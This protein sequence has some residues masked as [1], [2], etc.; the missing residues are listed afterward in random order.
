MKKENLLSIGAL[1]KQT[2]VHIKSLRYYDSLGI[3]RPAYVDPSSGYRYY[4]L[5]QIPVVDAIQLCVDLDI[6][7]KHFTDYYLDS[8][9][10]IHYSKL[11][12]RGTIL[13]KEKIQA[14]QERLD[15]LEEMRSEIKRGELIQKS[16]GMVQCSFP[17]MNLLLAPY[18]END[19]EMKVIALFHKLV[20]TAE[21]SGLTIN[22]FSGRLLHCRGSRREL[23]FY[24]GVDIPDGVQNF[25]EDLLRLPAGEYLCCKQA[26]PAIENAADIFPEQFAMDYEKYVIESEL[27]LGDYDCAAP[28]FELCC[29]LPNDLAP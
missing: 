13:A 5:Q 19:A 23:L 15:K 4:S 8:S 9:S 21:S 29:S 2:G 11:I 1:S 12:E 28:P 17:D 6:P 24:I 10:Q 3:L 27:S 14:I 16:D 20:R 7:L 22:Y 26:A 25:P 18:P